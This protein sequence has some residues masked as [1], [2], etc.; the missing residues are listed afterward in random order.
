[1]LNENAHSTDEELLQ[2]AD[3]ELP[4]R[5]A[6]QVHAHLAACWQCRARMSEIEA[7]IAEFMRA[8]RQ[9]ID[10]QLPPAAGPRALLRAQLAVLAST[11]TSG[12]ER[13]FFQLSA[14]KR[15]AIF[16]CAA[17]LIAV[18]SGRYFFQHL[19]SRSTN[20]MAVP[21]ERGVVPNPVLTPGATRRVAMS[22]VCSMAHE[23]VVVEVS[24][25]LRQE[26]FREYGIVNA[27]PNDYEIDYLIAPRLGGTDD[28]HNLWPQPY[29]PSTWN[30]HVKDALEE[31]LHQLVCAGDLDLST[32]QRDIAT[33]WIAAYKKYF[34]TDKPLHVSGTKP[35]PPFR[36]VWI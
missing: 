35:I 13:W 16:L 12:S 34:H 26:V 30:A 29:M 9:T 17:I 8:H 21:S 27:R 15:T 18:A 11:S 28:I 3:G 7:T 23:E 22:E 33:D 36:I 4:D 14:V 1:M 19:P 31:H 10:P 24:S 6:A 5:H 20:S 25:S 32:A 2:A